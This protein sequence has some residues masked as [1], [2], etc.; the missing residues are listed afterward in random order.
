M[1]LCKELTE[2]ESGELGLRVG[3]GEGT[4]MVP[5]GP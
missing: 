3:A 1:E 2:K 4:Q 5:A